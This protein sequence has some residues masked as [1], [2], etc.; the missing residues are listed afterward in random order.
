MIDCRC[1]QDGLRQGFAEMWAWT[2][3]KDCGKEGTSTGASKMRE[4]AIRYRYIGHGQPDM[5]GDGRAGIPVTDN[6]YVVVFTLG[7]YI[8]SDWY[9]LTI[10]DKTLQLS[11]YT[12]KEAL[13]SATFTGTK[14]RI[15]DGATNVV[16]IINVAA[17]LGPAVAT[18]TNAA[19][20]TAAPTVVY[21]QYQ[22]ADNKAPVATQAKICTL[23]VLI[24]FF[25]DLLVSLSL[26]LP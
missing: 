1:N 10:N 24:W 7:N 26:Q 15:R 25:P 4:L 12:G 14:R 6:G 8:T 2:Y 13:G 3:W 18:T 19:V 22:A 5:L 17:A 20:P 23:P 16:N 9:A 11:W 21:S